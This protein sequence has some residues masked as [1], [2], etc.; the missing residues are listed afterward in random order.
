M[1]KMV[2]L[3]RREQGHRRLGMETAGLVDMG[4]ARR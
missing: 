3:V 1:D 4:G 2:M